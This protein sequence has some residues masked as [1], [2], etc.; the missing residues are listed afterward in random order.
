MYLSVGDVENQ[1]YKI[2]AS[3]ALNNKSGAEPDGSA[4]ILRF[5]LDGKPIN[6]GIIGDKYHLN[7]YCAYG[8][9]NSFDMGFDP[10]I[11]KLWGSENSHETGDEINLI[12]PRFNGGWNKVQGILSFLDD[13]VPNACYVTYTSSDLVTFEGK[14]KY[15]S[16][17]F[18]WNRTVGYD[19]T[20]FY[21]FR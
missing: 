3:K 15:H 19:W 14:G 10:L 6:G 18:I 2:M 13:F 16:P 8:I 11:G 21:D 7:L 20:N 5:T 1:Y 4:G 12:E 17:D 9:R